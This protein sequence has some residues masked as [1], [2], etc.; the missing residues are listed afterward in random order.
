[1][2]KRVAWWLSKIGREV[3]ASLPHLVVAVVG[4]LLGFLVGGAAGV[5]LFPP[6]PGMPGVFLVGGPIGAM[7]GVVVAGRWWRQQQ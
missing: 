6:Q 3:L 5:V 1:M 7:V 2:K 4:A